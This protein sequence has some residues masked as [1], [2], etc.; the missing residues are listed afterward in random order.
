MKKN[1]GNRKSVT[2]IL[3]IAFLLIFSYKNIRIA[4]EPI[5][6]QIKTMISNQVE[7]KQLIV[8]LEETINHQVYKR[9]DFI[10]RYGYLQKLLNKDEVANFEVIKDK[11][12]FMHYSYFA[13]EPNRVE[14]LINR[15]KALEDSLTNKETKLMYIMPPD[16]YIRGY[17]EFAS[18]LPYNYANETADNFLEGL[19]NK[20]IDT[21]DLRENILQS[22][23][24]KDEL[25][26]KTDHHWTIQTAFW[27]F[28]EVVQKINLE[29]GMALDPNG[30]YTQAEHY[31]FMTYK[32]SF[33]GSMG[34]KTGLYYDGVDD[35]TV[36]YPKF[37]TN[38][39]VQ[40]TNQGTTEKLQGRFEESLFLVPAFR[41]EG[42]IYD[43]DKY[44]AYLRGNL[45]FVHI[46][47]LDQADG[48]K[49]LFIKDSMSV[50]MITFLS[51][52]FSEIYVVDPRYYAEDIVE[53]VNRLQLDFVFLSMY[54]PNLTSDFF[55]F[56]KEFN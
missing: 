15:V 26:F 38:Y 16:K 9:Y 23:I 21:L 41:Q 24:P 48:P 47:N 46:M 1:I 54:P 37:D 6:T 19:T 30:F 36:I 5:I 25:F 51:R 7:G 31:N 53:L 49:A 17:T 39:I 43:T 11:N 35:F 13:H 50:P 45:P 42:N 2:A 3:F 56:Y 29:Y 55:P 12:D 8:E 44:F 14:H 10:E 33:V 52:V 32:Q 22:G 34:R 27:A 28:G 18:G 20:G 40:S 4:Y